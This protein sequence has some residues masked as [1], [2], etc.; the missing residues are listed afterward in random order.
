MHF[1]RRSFLTT[2]AT[3]AAAPLF[4]QEKK[5]KLKVGF[6]NFAVRALGWKGAQLL[7][8]AVKLK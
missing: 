4:A 6:D 8:H 5:A 1:S 3:A 7:D 2:L